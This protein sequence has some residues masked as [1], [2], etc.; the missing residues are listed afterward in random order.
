MLYHILYVIPG[1]VT[2]VI[3]I[4]GITYMI[5]NTN[6]GSIWHFHVGISEIELYV[7]ARDMDVIYDTRCKVQ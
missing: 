7:Y 5:S 4:L 6:T 2:Y 1:Y 3:F